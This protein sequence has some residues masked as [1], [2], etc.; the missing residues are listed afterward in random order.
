MNLSNWIAYYAHKVYSYLA[1]QDAP[2]WMLDLFISIMCHNVKLTEGAKKLLAKILKEFE[3]EL[4]LMAEELAIAEG[5]PELIN[6]KNIEDAYNAYKSG[7][8]HQADV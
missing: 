6:E 5:H 8:R 2:E 4:L 1:L 3:E 7:K